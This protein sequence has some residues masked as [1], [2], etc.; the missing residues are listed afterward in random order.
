MKDEHVTRIRESTADFSKGMKRVRHILNI[1]EAAEYGHYI[2]LRVEYRF[3]NSAVHP[4]LG[5]VPYRL[6]SL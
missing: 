4:A 3:N 2:K 5:T 6:L 1:N